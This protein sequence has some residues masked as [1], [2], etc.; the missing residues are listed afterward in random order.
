MMPAA[1]Q[2][3]RRPA[4][5]LRGQR[6]PGRRHSA[7]YTFVVKAKAAFV[8]RWTISARAPLAATFRDLRLVSLAPHAPGNKPGGS[9]S[10]NVVLRYRQPPRTAMS[11]SSF[12]FRRFASLSG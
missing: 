5:S 6:G 12:T 4:K 7:E 8:Q 1:T 2:I 10:S 11:N 9:L 3:A